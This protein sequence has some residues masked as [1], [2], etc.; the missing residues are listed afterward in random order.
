MSDI[1]VWYTHAYLRTAESRLLGDHFFQKEEV[2]KK[3]LL[4]YLDRKKLNFSVTLR[5]L[6]TYLSKKNIFFS[7]SEIYLVDQKLHLAKN[8]FFKA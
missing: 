7:Y 5:N 6:K 4:T 3:G 2:V 8:Y 1:Y